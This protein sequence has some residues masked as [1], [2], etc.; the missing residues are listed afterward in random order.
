VLYS[1]GQ[2]LTHLNM[3]TV[4]WHIHRSAEENM[5][6]R[7]QIEY[8]AP[9]RLGKYVFARALGSSDFKLTQSSQLGGVP[10]E[11]FLSQPRALK[12]DGSPDLDVFAFVLKHEDD[13]AKLSVGSEVTL[14]EEP[15]QSTT[16]QRASRV[17][18]R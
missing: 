13:L 18:D 5:P 1:V 8:V 6:I 14:E 3:P 16:A 11:M 2:Y 15:I 4:S 17:A 12:E 10:V 9:E 7:M